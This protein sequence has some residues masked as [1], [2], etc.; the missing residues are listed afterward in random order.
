MSRG[1]GSGDTA[2]YKTDMESEMWKW[3]IGGAETGIEI[4]HRRK[5]TE[6]EGGTWAEDSEAMRAHILK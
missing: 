6:P 5:Y 3:G 2:C 1:R 4:Y